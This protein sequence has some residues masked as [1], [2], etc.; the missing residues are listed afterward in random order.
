MTCGL[1]PMIQTAMRFST[2]A[3][4]DYAG[5]AVDLDEQK[6]IVDDLGDADLMIPRNHG[7]LLV[8][9][10]VPQAFS[11]G[12]ILGA[13]GPT[14]VGGFVVMTGSYPEALA[15]ISLIFLLGLPTTWLAPETAGRALP[16]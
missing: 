1:L 11:F 6:R 5:V 14:I 10:T 16:A 15:I 8:G 12:R 7:L 4:H 2:V 13:L 9:P 3:D